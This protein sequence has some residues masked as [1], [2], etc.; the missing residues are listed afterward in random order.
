MDLIKTSC[1]HDFRLRSSVS[2]LQ[3]FQKDIANH[4]PSIPEKNA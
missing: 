2:F 4:V 3:S 1:M